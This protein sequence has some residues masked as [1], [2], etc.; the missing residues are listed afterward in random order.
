[1]TCLRVVTA[2]LAWASVCPGRADAA[3]SES[4]GRFLVARGLNRPE[5][6]VPIGPD[7]VLVAERSGRVLL[8]D[9]R[10]RLGPGRG[11][12]PGRA[13]ILRSGSAIHREAEGPGRGPR[14]ARHLP[15]VHDGQERPGRA[16]DRRPR[17]DPR[18]RAQ[19]PAMQNE[20]LWQS[21][22]QPWTRSDPPPFSGCRMAVDGAD[23]VV[24]LGANDRLTVSGRV[25]RVSMSGGYGPQGVST[26]HRNPGGMVVRSGVQWEIEHGPRGGDELNIITQGGDYGWPAVSKGTPDDRNHPGGFVDSRAGSVEPVVPWTPAIAPSSM[27]L[28]RGSLYVGALQGAAFVELTVD[29]GKIVLAAPHGGRRAGA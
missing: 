13:H 8:L 14:S 12:R 17:E 26:G 27:T 24:A 16:V 18:V 10:E 28:W 29:G 20:V 23:V 25:V 15:V 3:G 11:R 4:F 7:T 2:M 22:P 9:D 6:V 21:E 1:M 19:P 5:A